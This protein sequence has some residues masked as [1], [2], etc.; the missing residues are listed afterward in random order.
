MLWEKLK[1]RETNEEKLKMRQRNGKTFDAHRLKEQILLKYL[2]YPR[3][4][5]I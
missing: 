1:M 5:H 2:Y 3:N 4:L